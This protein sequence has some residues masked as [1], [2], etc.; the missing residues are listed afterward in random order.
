[1]KDLQALYHEVVHAHD[2]LP[3]TNQVPEKYQDL[4][5]EAHE[6]LHILRISMGMNILAN[7]PKSVA[8]D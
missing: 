7:S 6:K 1:M 2:Q 5:K 3:D 4:L 8:G